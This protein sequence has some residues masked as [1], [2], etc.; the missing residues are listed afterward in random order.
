MIFEIKIASSNQECIDAPKS[1]MVRSMHNVQN[2]ISSGRN[3]GKIY[4]INGNA[5][6]KWKYSEKYTTRRTKGS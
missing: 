5:I 2:D 4:D 6:G 3:S 1:V